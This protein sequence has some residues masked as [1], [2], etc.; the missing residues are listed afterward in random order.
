MS[1]GY[2]GVA[3]KEQE[4]LKNV[5]Y[6]YSLYNLNINDCKEND[7]SGVLEF[8]KDSLV[9]AEIHEK[10]IK[11]PKGRKKIVIKRIVQDNRYEELLKSEKIKI[12][13]NNQCFKKINGYDIVAVNLC[14]IILDEYQRLGFLPESVSFNV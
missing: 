6:K 4:T 5:K 14:S 12:I 8:E 13:N 3:I 2:G 10:R 9:E 11:T 7:Y 1:L